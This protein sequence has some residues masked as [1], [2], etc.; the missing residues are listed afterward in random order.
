MVN[1]TTSGAAVVK[2]GANVST[3]IPEGEGWVRWASQA[4][5]IINVESRR[6]WS[7]S[8]DTLNSD[9]KWILNDIA[10]DL[11][12]IRAINYDMSGYTSRGEAESMINILRDNA[13]RN[14][15]LI[16]EDKHKDF[17]E[18]A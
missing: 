14:I 8:Y 3:S 17:I 5:A 1:L 10:S 7:D 18:G 9:V 11:V 6:N 13:L 15:Q 4:T 16:T 12:A 2:A